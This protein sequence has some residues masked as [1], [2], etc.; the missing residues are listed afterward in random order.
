MQALRTN[1]QILGKPFDNESKLNMYKS[2]T[3]FWKKKDKGSIFLNIFKAIF[4][5]HICDEL[6]ILPN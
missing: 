4:N 3:K 5:Y 1:V 6:N 2:S